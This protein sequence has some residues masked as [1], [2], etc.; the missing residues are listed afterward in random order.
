MENNDSQLVP[1]E[2][3]LPAELSAAERYLARIRPVWQSTPLVRR[4]TRLLP[5]DPS[6]ACQRL[7]NAAGHDLQRKYL[8]YIHAIPFRAIMKR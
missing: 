8:H 4:V 6:S 2:A 5:V 3:R 1:Y 7:L